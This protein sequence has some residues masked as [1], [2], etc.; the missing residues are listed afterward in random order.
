MVHAVNI[1][2]ILN[3]FGYSAFIKKLFI[4]LITIFV[5]ILFSVYN[6]EFYV[7]HFHLSSILSSVF[8]ITLLCSVLHFVLH[9][10]V[11]YYAFYICLAKK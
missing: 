3:K 2:A 9:M 11:S 10:R 1:H 5:C 7:E 8:H 6:T 4:L